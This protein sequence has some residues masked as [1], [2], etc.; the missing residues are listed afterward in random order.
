MMSGG[1]FEA[2]KMNES[3]V[4]ALGEVEK[5]IEMLGENVEVEGK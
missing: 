5:I 2:E 3:Q 4:A 1:R